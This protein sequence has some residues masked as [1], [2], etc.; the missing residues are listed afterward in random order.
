MAMT[1]K[2][3]LIAVAVSIEWYTVMAA[4]SVAFSDLNCTDTTLADL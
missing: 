1:Y 2:G 3:R 4:A